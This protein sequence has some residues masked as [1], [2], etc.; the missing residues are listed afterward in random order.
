MTRAARVPGSPSLEQPDYWW[1]RARAGLLAAFFGPHL[2]DGDL[3]LD[4]GSADGPSLGWVPPSVRRVAMDLDPRGLAPGDGVVGDLRRLPFGPGRFDVVGAFDVLEHCEPESA[5]LDE[6]ARVL[7]P[8][9]RLMVAVPAYTWAWTHH[10]VYN[11]HH[12]RYT[13]RRLAGA[14]ALAGFD[15]VRT[16]HAFAGVFPI[17]AAQRLVTRVA[18][19][20]RPAH[21]P[22]TEVVSVPRLP[23]VAER[24]MMALTRIDEVA[25]PRTDLPFGSSVFALAVKPT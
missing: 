13:R 24:A 20:D 3:M 18:E 12:R 4:V 9:G 21:V 14:L 5:A 16:T 22:G 7:R 6:A 23:A 2:A 11:A 15:V 17:F 25:L 10:D 8:G 19:R 1:Y